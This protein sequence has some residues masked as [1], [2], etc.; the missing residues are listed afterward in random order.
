MLNT[1]TTGST[2]K[3]RLLSHGMGVWQQKRKSLC[4]LIML[5]VPMVL[6]LSFYAQTT[7][8]VA[9]DGLCGGNTPCYTTINSA[10]SAA[11]G[12]DEINVAPGAYTENVVVNKPLNLN[13]PNADMACGSRGAEATVAPST[14]LPFNVTAD[15]VE[16]NGFE[17]TSPGYQF[18][19]V[20]GN[21]GD[22]SIAFNYIHDIGTTVT[23]T[24]V[25]AVQYTVANGGNT[26]NVEVTDNCFETI[27]SVDLT[28]FS[29]SAIGFLQSTST[30]VLDGLTIARNRIDGV[31]VNNSN[32]PTGKIAYGIQINTGGGSGFASSTGNVRN[33][34]IQDNRILNLSGFIA[35]GI[36]LEGG[37]ENAIVQGNDI[38]NIAGRKLANRAGGGYD[39]NGLKIENN[40]H[41]AT[42]T[43]QNNSFQS[44]TFVHDGTAGLGYAISNY[45]PDSYGALD[46][47]CNWLGTNDYA[48][49]I[50]NV[51]LTGKLFAKDACEINLISFL[52]GGADASSA[53]GFQPGSTVCTSATPGCLNASACNYNS[54]AG[55][56]DGS[57]T[58]DC[59][60]CTE[61]DPS[62]ELDDNTC[63]LCF[64][65]EDF[66]APVA[67][68]ASQS[69]EAGAWYIDRYAPAGFVG[70]ASFLS[71]QRLRH[72]ISE[73]DGGQ[74]RPSGLQGDFYDT[75]GRKFDLPNPTKSLEIE[76]YVPADWETTNRRM[77]GLWGTGV[78]TVNAITSY[79]IIEFTSDLATPRFRGWG[80]DGW[81]DIGLPAG[82]AY[83]Q[84]YTLRINLLPNGEF[85]YTIEGGSD[86]L[87]AATVGYASA[88]TVH[89]TNVILQGHNT[90]D[91]VNYT[92][93][94]DNFSFGSTCSEFVGLS[95]VELPNTIEGFRTYQVFAEFAYPNDEVISVYGVV[96][97]NETSPLS[98]STSGVFYQDSN[99]GLTANN[100]NTALYPF[101]PELEFDSWLT[102][103]ESPQ[104]Q[105]VQV[106]GIAASDFGVNGLVLNTTTG[107]LWYVAPGESPLAVAGNNPDQKVLLGQFTTDGIVDMTLNIQYRGANG[108]ALRARQVDFSFPP[109][110]DGCTA[111]GACNYNPLATV[112]NGSCVLP[113]CTDAA[114]C[115]YVPAAGCDNGSCDYSCLT[116]YYVNDGDLTGDVYASSVG[117]DANPG[118]SA[119]PL[120]SI[121]AAIN[122]ASPGDTIYVDAGVFVQSELEIDK[123]LTLF[124]ANRGINPNTGTRI[125]ETVILPDTTANFRG[126]FYIMASDVTFD[127]FTMDADNPN[128]FSDREG[129]NADPEFS[130]AIYAYEGG[131]NRLVIENNIFTNFLYFAVTIYPFNN[132]AG[133]PSSGHVVSN[134]HFSD[135]GTYDPDYLYPYW[136][137]AVLVHNNAYAK[138]ENNVMENVRIGVQTG[139]FYQPTPDAA[140]EHGIRN[141]NV[142][143]RRRGVF[144]NLAYSNASLYPIENNIFTALDEAN[145][146]RW[147]GILFSSLSVPASALNNAIDGTLATAASNGYEVW[148]VSPD[149]N[150]TVGG[151]TVSGVDN[152]IFMNN[153]EGY[154]SNGNSG[155]HGSFEAIT[156]S[157]DNHAVRLLDSPNYTGTAAASISAQVNNCYLTSG[158][159]AIQIVDTRLNAVSAVINNNAIAADT[160]F[161]FFTSNSDNTVDLTCN[162]FGTGVPSEIS[163]RISGNASFIP[164]LVDGTDDNID[165]GFQP[166]ATACLSVVEGCTNPSACNYDAAATLDNG[167][168][169]YSCI[170]CDNGTEAGSANATFAL[171]T[172]TQC[173]DIIDF[174]GPVAIGADQAEGVWFTDRYAPSVFA[175]G[176]SFLGGQRLRHIISEFD[177]GQY[178]PTNLQGA[179]YETQGRKYDLPE[180]TRSMQIELYVPSNWETTGRRMAGLWGTAVNA[181]NAISGYPIIEFASVDGY[182]RFRGW[183]GIDW[184]DMGLPTGFTYNSWY[185]LEINLLSNGQF[186]YRVGDLELATE[187]FTPNASVTIRDV[188]LQGHNTFDGV[189][190]VIHWDNFEYG[191]GLLGCTD[192]SACN[193][194]P[195]A[196]CDDNSCIEAVETVVIDTQGAAPT[197]FSGFDDAADHMVIASD[198]NVSAAISAIERFVGNIDPN[199]TNLY[200]VLSGNSPTSAGDPT[201]ADG[202][203]RWNY[204]LQIDLGNYTFNDVDVFLD[205]DWD[206]STGTSVYSANYAQ[207]LRDLGFGA[208]STYQ[209]AQ[210]LG[211]SFWAAVGDPAILPFDPFAN[212]QYNLTLRIVTPSGAT[213]VSAPMTVEVFTPGCTNP[214]ACN[215][216]EDATDDDGS[217]DL[218]SCADCAGVPNG[219]ASIDDCGVC[220]GGTTGIT[221][222]STCLDCAGVA[223]GTAE[224]DDCGVCAGGTTG[225]TPNST[226]LDCAGIV[227]GTASIDDCGVCS[228]G[229]TGIVP[230]SSCTDCAGV[231]N[232]TAFIDDCG[233]CSG[234]TTGNTPNSSCLDCAGV[235]N[236]GAFFDDCGQCVEGSTGL[237]ACITC[238]GDFNF[239]GLVNTS[240]LTLLL[241]NY[242]CAGTG[243]TAG[244]FNGDGIINSSDISNFLPVFGQ[245]C[246]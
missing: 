133:T 12:G 105:F 40:K 225:I 210:N 142:T 78:N 214:I 54:A 238:P 232:G 245:E 156:I 140:F 209:D 198:C 36:G 11:V 28:G 132:G 208:L 217:C 228:G 95:Y 20:C 57:C 119:A 74:F 178:R 68:G 162:W 19:I 80:P 134:N 38:S 39:L 126:L 31:T 163:S 47:S 202:L 113:G 100:I 205:I 63:A 221:P 51:D 200:R 121:A 83:N 23:P 81:F 164:L 170:V 104:A 97:P 41:V 219:T 215:F 8:Y 26:S 18:A 73:F 230:N 70:G 16:I 110:I 189:S 169:D 184:V 191:H 145:E 98:I 53:I 166:L 77:A 76:V 201:P 69:P 161:N 220:S 127:G 24:N 6:S 213:M 92:I 144:H 49:I 101:I 246:E 96:D 71:G 242:G 159:E 243:C 29:A 9:P 179:F 84:W 240:D 14:G 141:N 21:R 158:A 43:V 207:S 199:G 196:T 65:T 206:P 241:G 149:A 50:D 72:I 177:G 212:G 64:T 7:H 157:A 94:W 138:I 137:G 44:E 181:T 30:G 1:C 102:I 147:D 167:S 223:N 186:L 143:A 204:Y 197:I 87:M 46:V 171:G 229:T 66:D 115:N 244:D 120:A 117:D 3:R 45:V 59:Y 227:N 224:F 79:P 60:G 122:L 237:T 128:V 107:G 185:T 48:A 106:T 176:I 194:N 22:L 90:S 5:T 211:F 236:G 123:A 114:A 129:F 89:L 235:P 13:G 32:W 85:L 91:G 103:G 55:I 173:D 37:T 2:A 135:L 226:C 112:D 231:V 139:N 131:V 99:G 174:N 203:A 4:R 25:H 195:A 116:A 35:T 216:N 153:Y 182:A 34:L 67:L 168:C 27:G 75:Q 150:L 151:G 183:D 155:A 88:N 233:V 125:G 172:C 239:D 56:D 222:N 124:G 118:T 62:A 234:G 188:I 193:Y 93:H 160:G 218:V 86:P 61:S 148:N 58:F 82:F 190:Y 15:G 10:I 17:I 152:G 108:V 180:N 187:T 175:G 165:Q 52:D 109:A 111:V 130:D 192:I 154:N 146:S 42:I 33:A 136:G